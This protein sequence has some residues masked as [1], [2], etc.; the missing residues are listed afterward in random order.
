M[1]FP[2]LKFGKV[3][4]P[5]DG[6]WS[7]SSCQLLGAVAVTSPMSLSYTPSPGTMAFMDLRGHTAWAGRLVGTVSGRAPSEWDQAQTNR[8]CRRKT[9]DSHEAQALGWVPLMRQDT[10]LLGAGAGSRE[11]RLEAASKRGFGGHP[12]QP[13]DLPEGLLMR[14]QSLA[15]TGGESCGFLPA[16]LSEGNMTSHLR[17]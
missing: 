17:V 11:G 5:P 15:V 14:S 1:S 9:N 8:Q 7:L 3:V 2:T 16:L 10:W 13:P 12:L 6:R 4:P